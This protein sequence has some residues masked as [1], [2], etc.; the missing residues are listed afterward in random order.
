M[1]YIIINHLPDDPNFSNSSIDNNAAARR[2]DNTSSI[3]AHANVIGNDYG[4]DHD[5]IKK[6][7]H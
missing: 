1:D 2:V 7:T 5:H 6:N 4:E 3:S